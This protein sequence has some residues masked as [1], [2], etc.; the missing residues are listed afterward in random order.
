MAV[1]P[2]QR[3]AEALR[4]QATGAGRYG[5]HGS[6]EVDV[7]PPGMRP[8]TALAIALIAGALLGTAVALISLLAPG[9]LP[10]TA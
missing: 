2:E 6:V 1:E 3:L 10:G 9:L 7:E 5:A 4:A 8:A